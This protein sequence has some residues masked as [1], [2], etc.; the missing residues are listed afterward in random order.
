MAG[1]KCDVCGRS[2]T[3]GV[4]SSALG[5]VSWAFCSECLNKPAE[6]EVMFQTTADTTGGGKGAADW[7]ADIHTYKNGQYMSW[8]AWLKT[9]VPTEFPDNFG[10][11]PEPERDS[12]EANS[13]ERF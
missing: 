4:A 5:A 3:V 1:D 9:Y 6:P 2:P 7:V 11:P 8:T 12:E 10:Y 13:S